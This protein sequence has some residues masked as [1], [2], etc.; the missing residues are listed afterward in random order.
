MMQPI[1]ATEIMMPRLRYIFASLALPVLGL[2]TAI[3]SPQTSA[4]VAKQ[5]A[6]IVKDQASLERLLGNSGVAVQW[7]GWT[8]ARGELDASWQGRALHL[9]GGQVQKDGTG[10]LS[11]DGY[12]VSI[13]KDSFVFRGTI[14]I[15]DTPDQGRKCVKTGDMPFA[16]TQ[17]RQYWRMR[18]FEWCDQLTDY[19]DI[20]F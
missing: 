9:K 16:I 6:T 13:G 4:R 8:E 17:N 5:P 10:K 2:I 12:V 7:L 14:K 19:I 1:I 20:Y 3:A 11:L 15:T 18:E